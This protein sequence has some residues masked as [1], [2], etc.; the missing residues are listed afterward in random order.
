MENTNTEEQ[1]RSKKK[2]LAFL[3]SATK[4][5]RLLTYIPIAVLS[6]SAYSLRLKNEGLVERVGRLETMNNALISNMILYNRNFETFPMPVFQKL[7]RGNRFIAQYF[8]PAYVAMMGHN[9]DYD[10]YRYIGKTDYEYYPKHI[11]DL[12]YNYDVSVAF[13]GTPMNIKVAITDSLG[14]PLKVKVMKWRH[15]RDR[16]TLVY[17]MILLD[18]PM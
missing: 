12:Y 14:N 1:L 17:G 11:A 4:K 16:D 6:V 18:Q 15:I 13:T 9:F 2:W 10:R 7:K 5:Y 8:N 3:V